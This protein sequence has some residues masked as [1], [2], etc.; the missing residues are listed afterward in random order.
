MARHVVQA[1]AA[2]QLALDIGRIG[3]DR[4]ERVGDRRRRAEQQRIDAEQHF[5]GLVGGAADHDAVDM[6]ADA[7]APRRDRRRRR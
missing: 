6:G 2:R 3:L 7:R 5:R 1:R 4:R